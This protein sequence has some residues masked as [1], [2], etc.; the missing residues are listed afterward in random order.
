MEVK[1]I[2]I[3]LKLKYKK[4]P[5]NFLERLLFVFLQ[6]PYVFETVRDIKEELS[7]GETIIIPAGY[8]TDLSSVPPILWGLLPPFG[9]FIRGALVHDWIYSEDYKREEMGD[10]KNRLFADREMLI[11]SNRDNSNKVDNYL[12]YYSVRLFGKWVYKRK[13]NE[14]KQRNITNN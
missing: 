1:E 9:C 14:A 11:I 6:S 3:S 13:K 12:R 2:N 4:Q 8:E 7:T 5:R 10:Y